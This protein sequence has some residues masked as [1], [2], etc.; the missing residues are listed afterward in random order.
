ML[1][2]SKALGRRQNLKR[3]KASDSKKGK[4]YRGLFTHF[5][6]SIGRNFDGR[7]PGRRNVQVLQNSVGGE[8]QGESDP[9]GIDV[10]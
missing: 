9:T 6:T 3:K 8:K 10:D 1:R 5:S 7:Q 2:E 4:Q